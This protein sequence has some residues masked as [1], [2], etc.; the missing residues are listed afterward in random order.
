MPTPRWS[1][2]CIASFTCSNTESAATSSLRFCSGLSS[3]RGRY[4]STA[5]FP[6]QRQHNAVLVFAALLGY[7]AVFLLE[8]GN[9]EIFVW[10]TVAA[11]LF[12]FQ[13]RQDGRAALCFG[14]A[15]AL[16]LYPIVL[17]GLFFDKQRRGRDVLLGLTTAALA[18]ALAI[19]Y[20][21]PTFAFAA[22]GFLH[23]VTGFQQHYGATV[24]PFELRF[25]HSLF[26]IVKVVSATQG[27]SPARFSGAYYAVCG[28]LF[29]LL[30]LLRVLRLP[31][32]N[33]VLF[34]TVAMLLLPPVSYEYTLVHLYVPVLLLAN[35]A[36]QSC[37]RPGG[38]LAWTGLLLLLLPGDLLSF[39]SWFQAGQ[40]QSVLLVFVLAC[41][42]FPLVP[43]RTA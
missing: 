3:L 6:R 16:K 13:R 42:C 29:T 21:G 10:A 7:P 15:A 23:G 1:P 8:R 35:L 20:T 17:L 14:L 28:V 12:F 9:L 26:A 24:R 34:L 38:L 5:G 27:L 37:F 4:V 18:T 43:A 33:Q 25:D 40:V 39:N 11:G 36:A 41:A 19:G 31:G 22:Q 32:V 30:F 2:R